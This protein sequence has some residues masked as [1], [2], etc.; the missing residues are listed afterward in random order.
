VGF[1]YGFCR[2]FAKPVPSA[3]AVAFLV[4]GSPLLNYS[5]I[6]M[7]MGHGS[8]AAAT[9][10]FAW[11]WAATF[12]SPLAR[13]WLAVG[14]LVGLAALMRWQLATLA[15]L[16]VAE[17]VL[18]AYRERS[19][20]ATAAAAARLA[21]AGLAAL[22]VF[23]PQMIAWKVLYGH[24]FVTPMPL[25]HNWL[26]PD[27]ARVLVGTDRSLFYWTPLVALPLLGCL[28]FSVRPIRPGMGPRPL[29]RLLAGAFAVQVYLMA[30]ISG[31]GVRLGDAF[32][33]RPLTE[34]VV[35]L[36]PGLALLLET[37]SPRWRRCLLAGCLLLIA[38]NG[39]LM[40]EYHRGLLPRNAGASPAVLLGNVWQL[41]RTW[42][43]GAVLFLAGPVLL[44]VVLLR[45][46][47]RR[48][49]DL[50]GPQLPYFR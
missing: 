6:E 33:F 29:L 20:R 46:G 43:Q 49:A 19:P 36:A 8:A 34:A 41:A 18:A 4:L 26:H 15:L 31:E 21:L 28:L 37:T 22:A 32:G 30:S 13:R 10:L 25:A 5:A 2:L 23:L 39:L 17:F 24:W 44:L 42:L 38:W 45:H 16:P 40:A 14:G 1:L 27:W 35:L 12:G 50:L 47:S 3:L 9:A 7:A 48:T 11:Y